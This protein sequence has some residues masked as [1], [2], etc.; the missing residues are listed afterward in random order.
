MSLENSKRSKI[1][2]TNVKPI[3]KLTILLIISSLINSTLSS[4]EDIKNLTAKLTTNQTE[5][6]S[7]TENLLNNNY[8][9][10]SSVIELNEANFH[11]EI[12]KADCAL[13]QFSAPWCQFCKELKPKFEAAAEILK[14]EKN[15]SIKFFNIDGDINKKITEEQKIFSFPTLKVYN[16]KDFNLTEY[17]GSRNSAVEIAIQMKRICNSNRVIVYES[18][19]QVFQDVKKYLNYVVLFAYEAEIRKGLNGQKQNNLSDFYNA[20]VDLAEFHKD[21]VFALC[22]LEKPECNPNIIVVSENNTKDLFEKEDRQTFQALI[23]SLASAFNKTDNPKNENHNTEANK[24]FKKLIIL[25]N[26]TLARHESSWNSQR[27]SN[28]FLF[29]AYEENINNNIN[30]NINQTLSKSESEPTLK[31]RLNYFLN[32]NAYDLVNKLEDRTA[33]LIFTAG[34]SSMFFFRNSSSLFTQYDQIIFKAAERL[35][36]KMF[37]LLADIESELESRFADLLFIEPEDLPELRI[38]Y[39][40]NDE[41]IRTYKLNFDFKNNSRKNLFSEEI[42][43]EFYKNYTNNLLMPYYKSEPISSEDADNFYFSNNFSSSI[44]N[45]KNINNDN[46]TYTIKTNFVRKVVGSTYNDLVYDVSRHRMIKIYLPWDYFCKKLKPVYEELA[47][48]FNNNKN[49]TDLVFTELDFSKNEVPNNFIK[50]YPMIY[51][52]AKGETKPEVYTGDRSFESLEDFVLVN[53]GLPAVNRNS[54]DP[55]YKEEEAPTKP[56]EEFFRVN[57]DD[58]LSEGLFENE[59]GIGEITIQNLNMNGDEDKRIL[60]ED[61]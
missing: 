8:L 34:V 53:M 4:E 37:F 41:E 30:N 28:N 31:E 1:Q 13:V 16:I 51:F 32:S 18:L 39:T 10:D 60:N 45:D 44:N 49:F 59:T 6:A 24:N 35:K 54:T 33:E 23:T 57:K 55:D 7:I 61:L 27:P 11:S 29:R 17:E 9:T 26:Q 50:A 20:L 52:F 12:E 14:A 42:I 43:F 21:L 36:G 58:T 38:I 47:E 25:R 22:P 15:P 5:N 2:I 3:L 40:L 19:L 46:S 56:V 48:K